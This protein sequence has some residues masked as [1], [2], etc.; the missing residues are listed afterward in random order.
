MITLNNYGKCMP[1]GNYFME[2]RLN[3]KDLSDPAGTHY[4]EEMRAP[5]RDVFIN[6]WH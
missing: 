3:K 2:F 4:P 6:K 5:R 1:I